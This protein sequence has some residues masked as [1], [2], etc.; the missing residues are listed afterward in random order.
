MSSQQM[1]TIE[2]I[3]AAQIK[4]YRQQ[5]AGCAF[6][7]AAANNPAK[8]DWAQEVLPINGDA[9]DK[10]ISDAIDA[11][12]TS[13]ISLIFPSVV[14]VDDLL[15]LIEELASCSLIFLEERSLF[16][17]YVCLAFRVRLGTKVSWV[18]GFGNFDFFPITRQ[19]PYTEIAFR[20][21]PR[22]DYTIVLKSAPENVLHLA[23]LSMP[24]FKR[25]TFERMWQSSLDHTANLLG[26]SPD[27]K[28]AAKTTFSLPLKLL[29]QINSH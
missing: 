25:S 17:D 16:E 15:H 23:D 20:V 22:P 13:T 24:G 10:T 28:S 12:G 4:F 11:E 21:K 5:L 3:K 29:P 14:T 8:Y 1:E 7:A 9:V 18:S 19:S 2:S 26:H 6:A 27:L